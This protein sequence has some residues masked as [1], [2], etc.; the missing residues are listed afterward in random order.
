MLKIFV[1]MDERTVSSLKAG[2]AYRRRLVQVPKNYGK[3]TI[4]L[5]PCEEHPPGTPVISVETFA[6]ET[7]TDGKPLGKRKYCVLCWTWMDAPLDDITP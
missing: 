1:K 4:Y 3:R 5:N 6:F 2:T 7:G